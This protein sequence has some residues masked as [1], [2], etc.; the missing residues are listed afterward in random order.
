MQE[1]IDFMQKFLQMEYEVKIKCYTE[2][3]RKK[4]NELLQSFQA[5]SNLDYSFPLYS[6]ERQ[7]WEA[8]S[9]KGLRATENLIPCKLYLVKKYTN[10]QYQEIYKCYTSG[11]KDYS[12][13]ILF[14]YYVAKVD[15]SFKVVSMYI[16]DDKGGWEFLKGEKLTAKGKL[17]EKAILIEQPADSEYAREFTET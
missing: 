14:L 2:M 9:E 12:N 5:L 15:G 3:D 16:P 6:P 11:N 13:D 1:A 7:S 4:F 10:K 17:L 8:F